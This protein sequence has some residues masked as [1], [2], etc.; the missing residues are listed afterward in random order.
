MAHQR[1]KRPT[2]ACESLNREWGTAE[3]QAGRSYG[4]NL[5]SVFPKSNIKFKYYDA[6]TITPVTD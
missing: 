1:T 4:C 6:E 3:S 5:T 2:E